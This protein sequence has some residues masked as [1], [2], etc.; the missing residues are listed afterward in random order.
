M[1]FTQVVSKRRTQREFSGAAVDRA[2]V[3]DLLQIAIQAPNHRRNEPW[4]FIVIEQEQIGP[5]W[6]RAKAHLPQA[7]AGREPIVIERKQEKLARRL[8][9]VGAIVYV[10][11]ARNQREL[12]ERENYAATC[13]AVQNLL[14]AATDRGL[15]SFWSTGA[16]FAH[17]PVLD[18]LGVNTAEFSFVGAIWLGEPVDKP[19]PPGFTLQGHIRYWPA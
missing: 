10:L 17:P 2:T 16:L 9:T 7:L 1:E 12:V 4:Q 11:S 14:L 13:C 15:G 6:E 8:P 5:F 3:Q 19:E 18:L